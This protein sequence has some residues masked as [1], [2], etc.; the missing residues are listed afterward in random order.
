MD[1]QV[2]RDL[3]SLPD[4]TSSRQLRDWIV[5]RESLFYRTLPGMELNRWVNYHEAELQRIVRQMEEAR[6]QLRNPR[7]NAEAREHGRL[8]L[9]ARDG[10]GFLSFPGS[11]DRIPHTAR[12]GRFSSD[13]P[14]RA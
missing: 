3:D 8:A 10:I 7:S 2:A 11:H 1:L 14:V 4:E 9:Q 6:T 13:D 12:Y 5:A